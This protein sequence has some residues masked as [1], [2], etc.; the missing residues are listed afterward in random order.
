M[1]FGEGQ[2]LLT[3]APVHLRTYTKE[4]VPT[5]GS[6]L[7]TVQY[8]EQTKELP[9]IVVPGSGPNLCGRDWLAQLQLD[10]TQRATLTQVL[11]AHKEVFDKSL[12]KIEGF[13]AKLYVDPQ[14]KPLFLNPDKYHKQ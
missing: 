5:L 7:V 9:V 6:C 12:G 8:G 3:K 1:Q 13:K 4:E 14:V 11:N 2:I 10:W